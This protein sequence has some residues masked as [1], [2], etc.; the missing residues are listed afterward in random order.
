MGGGGVLNP[1]R[2]K[3]RILHLVFFAHLPDLRLR[4][5]FDSLLSRQVA[6][7]VLFLFPNICP[8]QSLTFEHSQFLFSLVAALLQKTSQVFI[9]IFMPFFLPRPSG[10]I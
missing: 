2:L 10:D 4:P 9:L 6:L 1:Y 3:A 5:L 8:L 7:L